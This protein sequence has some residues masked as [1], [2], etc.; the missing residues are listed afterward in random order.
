MYT[1]FSVEA[2]VEPVRDVVV[3]SLDMNVFG[4]VM[5][6]Q[7]KN[8]II[9]HYLQDQTKNDTAFIMYPRYDAPSG[10]QFKLWTSL[11]KFAFKSI[12]E[13]I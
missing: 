10:R 2:V 12:T 13:V 1:F 4:L 9:F 11:F 8:I 3:S 7:N 5:E 6:L